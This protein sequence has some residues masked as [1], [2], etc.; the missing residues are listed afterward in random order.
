MS[1]VSTWAF[2]ATLIYVRSAPNVHNVRRIRMQY[3]IMISSG[4]FMLGVVCRLGF[5]PPPSPENF[6]KTTNLQS[7]PFYTIFINL[8]KTQII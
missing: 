8:Y 1:P 6:F 3:D 7:R 4:I 2:M 5:Y